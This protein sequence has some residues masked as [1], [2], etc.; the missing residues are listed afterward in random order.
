[1]LGSVFSKVETKNTTQTSI[2]QIF[3]ELGK[4]VILR[5]EEV[6]LKK[7]DR[8]PH[9][10]EQQAHDLLVQSLNEY[11]EAVKIFAKTTCLA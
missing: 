10:N 7:G 4:G 5:G 1:M 8:I 11:Y 2:A 6:T 9:L 3:D